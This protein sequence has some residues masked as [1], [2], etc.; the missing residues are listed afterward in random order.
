MIR[1]AGVMHDLD[2]LVRMQEAS[3]PTA[4]A[5]RRLTPARGAGCRKCSRVG[6]RNRPKILGTTG[7]RGCLSPRTSAQRQAAR[8]GG[9][10]AGAAGVG[11]GAIDDAG[12]A[13]GD[14][15]A[16]G[17][18]A[19]VLTMTTVL[20]IDGAD[21]T[22]TQVQVANC[23]AQNGVAGMMTSLLGDAG[24][25]MA[26]PTFCPPDQRLT[27]SRVIFNEGTA[28]AVDVAVPLATILG[29]NAAPAGLPI[30]VE[31]GAWAEGSGDDVLDRAAL[32]DRGHVLGVDPTRH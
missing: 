5:E 28:G 20:P 4:R 29:L 9:A 7:A 12:G 22:S 15:G 3:D 30:K 17:D 14:D 32:L 6:T 31:S 18:G 11:R 16:G 19:Y 27:T 1:Q 8:A 24:F 25:T 10:G 13:I 23:S 26:E 2:A 21:F